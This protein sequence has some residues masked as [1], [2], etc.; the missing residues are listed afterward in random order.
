MENQIKSSQLVAKFPQ[1]IGIESF[2]ALSLILQR[3]YCFNMLEMLFESVLQYINF[4]NPCM[5]ATHFT[6]DLDRHFI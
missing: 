1:S 4:R 6:V 2:E 5:S 3:P